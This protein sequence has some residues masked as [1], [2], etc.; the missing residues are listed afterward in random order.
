MKCTGDHNRMLPSLFCADVFG[1]TGIFRS[2]ATLIIQKD[3][4]LRHPQGKKHDTISM[5]RIIKRFVPGIGSAALQTIASEDWKKAGIR[6]T[7]YLDSS[8][9]NQK[10][11]FAVLE[12]ELEKENIVVFDVESTGVDTLTDEIIQIAGIRLDKTGNIKEK[13]MTGWRVGYVASSPALIEAVTAIHS[14]GS[15]CLPGF[16]QD[17]CVTA[18]QEE[19]ESIAHMMAMKRMYEMD[20]A[21]KLWI[22]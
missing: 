19:D 22:E 14:Y 8:T 11:A 12:Q 6:L 3:P 5:T 2:I 4:I 13:F 7:D 20:E 15:S 18:L 10:D 16:I 17:A 1:K 9:L 21:V